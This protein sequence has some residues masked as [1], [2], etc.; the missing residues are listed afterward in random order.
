MMSEIDRLVESLRKRLTPRD[1]HHQC[2]E[3]K[4]KGVYDCYAREDHRD[5]GTLDRIL[6]LFKEKK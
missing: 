5:H 2:C 6:V 4:R 1:E 3:I